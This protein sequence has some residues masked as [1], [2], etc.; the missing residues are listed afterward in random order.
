M[1]LNEDL[2]SKLLRNVNNSWTSRPDV[3]LSGYCYAAGQVVITQTTKGC[4]YSSTR[5]YPPHQPQFPR[6]PISVHISGGRSGASPR[7]VPAET[8]LMAD[9]SEDTQACITS[10]REPQKRR[11]SDRPCRNWGGQVRPQ[12]N[13][14]VINVDKATLGQAFSLSTSLCPV[15]IFPP[16]LNTHPFIHHRRSIQG[17]IQGLWGLNL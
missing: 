3:S 8:G 12:S 1:T 14:C 13:P 10:V 5:S 11:N 4:S 6:R 2:Y 15:I 9:R 16:I 7:R 17:R